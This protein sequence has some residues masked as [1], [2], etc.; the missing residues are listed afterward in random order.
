[1]TEENS[2]DQKTPVQDFG[3]IQAVLFSAFRA[4]CRKHLAQ[5]SQSR[6]ENGPFWSPSEEGQAA[7]VRQMG[8]LKDACHSEAKSGSL[9]NSRDGYGLSPSY[10]ATPNGV[11]VFHVRSDTGGPQDTSRWEGDA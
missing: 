6:A 9:S 1:M 3:P 4:A 2:P 8:Y 10:C 7:R 5:G 11:G